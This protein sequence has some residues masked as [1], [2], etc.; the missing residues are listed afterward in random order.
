MA[1][2]IDRNCG[3]VW[4]WEVALKTDKKIARAR[5]SGGVASKCLDFFVGVCEVTVGRDSYIG[6]D[7]K[8]WGVY[9]KNLTRFHAKSSRKLARDHCWY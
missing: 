7:D 1:A 2:D 3:G 9:G 6:N 5:I 8:G 4:E